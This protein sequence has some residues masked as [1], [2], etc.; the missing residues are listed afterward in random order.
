[1]L[2]LSCARGSLVALNQLTS[3]KRTQ[4]IGC[5]V[6]G[7]SIRT[8]VRMTGV[9]KNTV[10]KLLVEIGRACSIY[11]DRIFRNLT[12][13][14]IQCDE[15]WSFVGAKEKNV[16]EEKK[17]EG[18]GDV[19]TWTSL[20]ADTKLVPCWYVGTRDSTAAYQFMHDIVDRLA[21]RVL[22]TTDGHRP[23]LVVVA[24]AFGTDVD[25]AQMVKIYGEDPKTEARYSP[26]QYMGAKKAVIS[27]APEHAHVS[28]SFVER[29]NLTLRMSNRRF[30][31]FADGCPK[32]VENHEYALALYFMHYNFC[33]VHQTLRCT[34]AMEAGIAD[35]VWSLS[36][37]IDLS[38]NAHSVAV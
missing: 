7:M 10:A 19:W 36:E 4:V 8:T 37:V 27:D 32:K 34:P 23:Y 14:R 15:I 3:E 12:C 17:A 35:H 33:R 9:A 25:Y 16:S 13:K 22:L 28:T 1:M 30:T 31:R 6:E 21:S 38:D 26:A 11:Q 5:L 18:W 24:D 29:S 2:D 20:C